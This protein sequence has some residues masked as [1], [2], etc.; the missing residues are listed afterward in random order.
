VQKVQIQK[1]SLAGQ[2]A[3][4]TC[5]NNRVS[6]M[7]A[8]SFLNNKYCFTSSS[9]K[10][11]CFTKSSSCKTYCLICWFSSFLRKS[12][13]DNSQGENLLDAVLS[14]FFVVRES[15][16]AVVFCTCLTVQSSGRGSLCSLCT[17]RLS[18][19]Q[20]KRHR[21]LFHGVKCSAPL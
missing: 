12:G 11:S 18:Y 10:T 15:R 8:Y 14:T 3:V 7:F 5:S 16:F 2:L 6:V 1:E 21:S 17:Y 4:H 19:Q 20:N 9:I 13:S